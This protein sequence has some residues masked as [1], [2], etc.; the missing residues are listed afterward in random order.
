L[1]RLTNNSLFGGIDNSGDDVY[2]LQSLGGSTV[3]Y[4]DTIRLELSNP[5]LGDV[6]EVLGT[7]TGFNQAGQPTSGSVTQLSQSGGIMLAGAHV[8]AAELFAPPTLFNTQK[9]FTDAF[10]GDDSITASNARADNNILGYDGADTI[11][12]SAA[13]QNNTLFGGAGADYLVGGPGFNRLN[14]NIGDDTIVGASKQGDCLLGG[15]GNDSI[16]ASNSTGHNALQGNIGDDT[17]H[18]GAGGDTLRGGKGQD[19]LEGGS[20]ADWISGDLGANTLT[21]GGGADTFHAGAGHDLVT[22][23][24][25]GEG[26]RISIDAGLAYQTSQSGSDVHI[27]LSNGGQ[28]V[29]QN[30]RL[31]SLGPESGWI[32]SG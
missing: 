20:G 24:T 3:L 5:R 10:A 26:D 12:A 31:S 23:F 30:T 2:L 22:D 29:L 6:W 15:Q 13:P 14:G 19:V 17:L 4:H 28:I 21:G 1:A 9:A 27:D 32:V 18:G 16:D 25:V 11:D 7:F 8:D